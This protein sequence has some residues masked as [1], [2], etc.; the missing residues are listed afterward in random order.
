MVGF[1]PLHPLYP[2]G[3]VHAQNTQNLSPRNI[4]PA[5]FPSCQL[6]PKFAFNHPILNLPLFPAF[7]FRISMVERD[8]TKTSPLP[9]LIYEIEYTS[10]NVYVNVHN[11]CVDETPYY[12]SNKMCFTY[13]TCSPCKVFMI[14]CLSFLSLYFFFCVLCQIHIIILSHIFC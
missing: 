5:L 11:I 7:P 6:L 2:P 8:F 10:V 12:S 1:F 14:F 9:V 4:P 3:A 13:Q